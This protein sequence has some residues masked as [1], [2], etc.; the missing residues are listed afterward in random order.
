MLAEDSLWLGLLSWQ[1]ISQELLL[2]NCQ[3]KSQQEKWELRNREG[4]IPNSITKARYPGMSVT[5]SNKFSFMLNS[6]WVRF[7]SLV[8]NRVL[9]EKR[10]KGLG[11]YK[12]PLCY[13]N[14]H[15]LSHHTSFYFSVFGQNFSY[16]K[17]LETLS[18]DIQ[19]ILQ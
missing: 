5:Q 17:G 2:S 15:F 18:E 16:L 14:S 19:V 10:V 4:Q 13:T 3:L 11:K 6:L 9:T 12:V 8:T 1:D 7:L